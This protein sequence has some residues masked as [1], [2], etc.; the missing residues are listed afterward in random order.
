[1]LVPYKSGGDVY[2]DLFSE[3]KSNMFFVH[4]PNYF[5]ICINKNDNV[6][7]TIDRFMPKIQRRREEMIGSNHDSVRLE[8]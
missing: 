7:E 3:K 8:T 5:Q 4:G 1:M 6:E 2:I